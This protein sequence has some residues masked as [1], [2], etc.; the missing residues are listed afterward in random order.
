MQQVEGVLW[1]S[2]SLSLRLRR[3]LKGD[4]KLMPYSMTPEPRPIH[5]LRLK[6]KAELSSEAK[7]NDAWLYLSQ[8]QLSLTHSI[9][10][11]ATATARYSVSTSTPY[12]CPC[13]CLYRC[14]YPSTATHGA[15]PLPLPLAKCTLPR[16]YHCYCGFPFPYPYPY[17]TVIGWGNA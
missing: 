7:P 4:R 12:A 15:T 6:P 9:I 1:R 10:T 5:K 11:T 17:P 2:L 16:G 14:N 8:H 13:R 3:E